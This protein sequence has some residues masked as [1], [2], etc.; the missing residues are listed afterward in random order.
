MFMK[1]LL[2]IYR[3][4]H[5]QKYGRVRYLYTRTVKKGAQFITTR[6][7]KQDNYRKC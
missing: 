5:K 2:I 4:N 7:R 3:N 6:Y 1:S